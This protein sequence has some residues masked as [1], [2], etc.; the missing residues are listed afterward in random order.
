MLPILCGNDRI[1]KASQIKRLDT[2]DMPVATPHM[3]R[4]QRELVLFASAA[5]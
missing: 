5:E 1:T 2:Y 4:E 3:G